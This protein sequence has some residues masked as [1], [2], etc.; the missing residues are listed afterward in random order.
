MNVK[1]NTNNV[2]QKKIKHK[3]NDTFILE[4]TGRRIILTIHDGGGMY[5]TLF[6][7]EIELPSGRFLEMINDPDIER[8]DHYRRIAERYMPDL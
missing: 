4:N 6:E 2:L 1:D 8:D 7:T 5:C 3:C